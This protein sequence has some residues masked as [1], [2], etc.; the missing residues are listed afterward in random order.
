MPSLKE[1]RWYRVAATRFLEATQVPW[2]NLIANLSFGKSYIPRSIL[3]Q[4]LAG[5]LEVT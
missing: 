4:S 5:A 1:R 3:G 2:D